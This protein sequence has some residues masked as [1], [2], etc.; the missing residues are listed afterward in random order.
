MVSQADSAVKVM[1]ARETVAQPRGRRRTP[2]V[3]VTF[4]LVP[5]VVAETISRHRRRLLLAAVV[6]AVFVLVIVFPP[7]DL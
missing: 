5:V 2:D 3:L 1:E 6:V 4:V 7:R